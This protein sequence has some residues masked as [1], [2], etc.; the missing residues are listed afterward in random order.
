M[1]SFSPLHHG[2]NDLDIFTVKT[3]K[4]KVIPQPSPC[5]IA[6]FRSLFSFHVISV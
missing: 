4:S 6:I 1:L 2:R 5:N 3:P